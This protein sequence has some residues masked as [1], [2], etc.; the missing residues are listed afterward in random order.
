M[1]LGSPGQVPSS[2]SSTPCSTVSYTT[3]W[4]LSPSC[5]NEGDDDDPVGGGCLS[6]MF[7]QQCPVFLWDPPTPVLAPTSWLKESSPRPWSR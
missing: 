6:L 2:P 5:V 7:W 1:T 3:S 4:A